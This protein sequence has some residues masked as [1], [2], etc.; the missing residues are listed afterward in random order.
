MAEEDSVGVREWG[1]QG[2]GDPRAEDSAEVIITME[3]LEGSVVRVEGLVVL[4]DLADLA[5][6]EVEDLVDLGAEDQEGDPGDGRMSV[7]VLR[8]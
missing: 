3:G 6:L 7:D 2:L 4:E 8:C 1:V 5:G